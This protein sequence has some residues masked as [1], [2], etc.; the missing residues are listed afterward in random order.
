MKRSYPLYVDQLEDRCVPAAQVIVAPT[1]GVVPDLSALAATPASVAIDQAAATNASVHG[2]A[3]GRMHHDGGAFVIDTYLIDPNAS[4]P[5][6]PWANEWNPIPQAY[7][8]Q[9]IDPL[10]P[11]I[12]GPYWY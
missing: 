10:A 3:S 12:A 1:P 4:P 2:A 6:K 8:Q 9:P 11:P 5:P 7:W